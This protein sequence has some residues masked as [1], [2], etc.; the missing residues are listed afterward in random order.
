MYAVEFCIHST[1]Q[2]KLRSIHFVNLM[3]KLNDALKLQFV[4]FGGGRKEAVQ[5]C[6]Q[7]FNGILNLFINLF[8][9]E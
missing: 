5:M 6:L 2:I 7:I 3:H 4:S 8:L 9:M 1:T